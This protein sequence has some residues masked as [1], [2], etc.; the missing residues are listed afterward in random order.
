MKINFPLKSSYQPY[1]NSSSSRAIGGGDSKDGV[2]DTVLSKLNHASDGIAGAVAGTAG[3]VTTGIPQTARV[4]TSLTKNVIKSE[5]WGPLL[6]LVGLPIGLAATAIGGALHLPIALAMGYQDGVDAARATSW[7]DPTVGKA[8]QSAYQHRTENLKD[9]GDRI[10]GGLNEFGDIK[11]APG[12]KPVELPLIR[13]AKTLLM[14]VAGTTIGGVAGAV[15]ALTATASSAIDRIGKTL[16]DSRVS[17]PKKIILSAGDLAMATVDGVKHG[18]RTGAT[19]AGNAT[20]KTWT[21]DSVT[22]GAS[23]IYKDVKKRVADSINQGQPHPT[24]A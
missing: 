21:N 19:V 24:N 1:Q 20:S 22:E 15:T 11:L 18:L 2:V 14:G 12:E 4:A 8:A 9:I 10:V 17:V 23:S 16:G 7:G 5:Q 13:T 3:W 6:K